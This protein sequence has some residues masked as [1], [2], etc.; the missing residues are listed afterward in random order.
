[1]EIILNSRGQYIDNYG[2]P[3]VFKK[4]HTYIHTNLYQEEKN[5]ERKRYD[6]Y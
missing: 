5:H 6:G 3:V 1:M 4:A 2:C